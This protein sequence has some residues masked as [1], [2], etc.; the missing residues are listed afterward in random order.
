MMNRAIVFSLV[1]FAFLLIKQLNGRVEFTVGS[2]E[3]TLQLEQVLAIDNACKVAQVHQIEI[4]LV[5][6]HLGVCYKLFAT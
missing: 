5:L 3:I 2:F 4:T 6:T 1:E